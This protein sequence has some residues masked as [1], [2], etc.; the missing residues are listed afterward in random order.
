MFYWKLARV[1][2]VAQ[3]YIIDIVKVTPAVNSRMVLNYDLVISTRRRPC[4]FKNYNFLVC[5]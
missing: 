4:N 1:L 5:Q 3:V 2:S